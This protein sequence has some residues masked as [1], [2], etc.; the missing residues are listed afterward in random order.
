MSHSADKLFSPFTFN[1]LTIPNRVVMAPMTRNFSPGEVPG[2]EVAAYYR[3]RAEG[4]TGLIITEGTTV[5]HRVS[6]MAE[7]IPAFYGKEALEGWKRVAAEVHEAGGKI[8]P[9]LW[10][11]GTM[12]NQETAPNPTEP[13]AGPSGLFVPGKKVADPMTK[14]DIQNTIDAFARAALSAREV[15]MDGI[16]LHGAHGYLIDQFFWEGTNQRD[17]EYGGASAVARTKFGVDIINA[18]RA[19]VGDD[20]PLILRFSQWK[21]QDFEHK[22]APDSDALAAF[23]KPLSDAGVDVFHCSTRR[24]WEPEFE[25]SDLNLAG[26]TKKL[27]GKPTITVGSVGLSGEFIAA[28][29]GEGSEPTSIDKLLDRL[30]KD[31]FDMV[32]VG[33]ALLVDPDWANKIREG[34]AGELKAFSQA[35]LAELV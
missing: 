21:Q 5:D 30:E 2:A 23:L 32:A 15:G 9:Q 17:D 10:H 4:G 16:E 6:T 18:V 13:S 28:F 29:A 24:F 3:R 8:M 22:I 20:F 26:W 14:E 7:T 34:R 33:R 11:V 35:A 27:T 31:E 1:G 25:G 19:E 12:R